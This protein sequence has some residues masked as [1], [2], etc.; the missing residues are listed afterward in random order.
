MKRRW[1]FILAA[2][3]L[4]L[5]L[6][7]GTA[8]AIDDPLKVI[9]GTCTFTAS[10]TPIY[11]STQ[12]GEVVKM[13]SSNGE[14]EGWN[15]KLVLEGG[16]PVLTLDGAQITASE[17]T[18]R[19]AGIACEWGD[20][21]I[22]L[23]GGDSTVKAALAPEGPNSVCA[24]YVYG[25]LKIHSD[26]PV[27]LEASSADVDGGTT[28]PLLFGINSGKTIE[29][30]GSADVKALAGSSPKNTSDSAG[31]L[32]NGDLVVRD[33]ARLTAESGLANSS[34]AIRCGN[35]FTVEG[36]AV[37]TA[38]APDNAALFPDNYGRTK[39]IS[40]ISLTVCGNAEVTAQSGGA[41]YES[42]GVELSYNPS[43]ILSISGNGRLSGIAGASK[44]S[45]GL[46]MSN[47]S[48]ASFN[49]GRLLV[50]GS[51]QDGGYSAFY[52]LDNTPADCIWRTGENDPYRADAFSLMKFTTPTSNSKPAIR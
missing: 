14:P 36:S 23:T 41:L 18:E 47:G 31:L 30:T 7:P 51:N 37:V 17:E 44:Y 1:L 24:L 25:N 26:S 27:A 33:S 40:T 9:V 48:T 10:E 6:L 16:T 39:G 38:I 28:R 43:S 45:Y 19:G 15:V 50:K 29:I 13:D 11:A 8:G 35:A 20:L 21:K 5:G 42:I 32:S 12:T 22:V 34:D 4:C 52:K 2:L 49:G 46:K 3:A